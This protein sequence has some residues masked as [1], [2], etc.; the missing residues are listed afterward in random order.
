MHNPGDDGL[1]ESIDNI[2]I[3]CC[4]LGYALMFVGR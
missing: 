2:F 1:G 4:D 3:T